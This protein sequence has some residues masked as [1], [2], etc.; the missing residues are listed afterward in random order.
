M[1]VAP[2]LTKMAAR[3]TSHSTHLSATI[4]PTISLTLVNEE[5]VPINTRHR[6]EMSMPKRVTAG[7]S[8]SQTTVR[9]YFDEWI[10]ERNS[11]L[12]AQ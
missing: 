12:C 9:E 3:S 10:T 8:H 11:M 5:T 6:V 4:S 7:I 2:I 1:M